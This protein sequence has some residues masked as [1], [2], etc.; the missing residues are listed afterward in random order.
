MLKITNKSLIMHNYFEV[1]QKAWG[2]FWMKFA[3]LSPAGRLATWIATWFSPPY[4]A[5]KYLARYNSQGFIS[6]SSAIY[7]DSIKFGNNVFI[8]DRVT[9]YQNGGGSVSLGD[10]VHLHQDSCVETGE[11]GALSIGN[12]T[13]IQSRCQFSAY[14][15]P[16]TIGNNVQIAPSCSFYSYDHATNLGQNI[17]DLPLSSKGGIVIDDDVWVGCGVIVLDG[18]HLGKGCV[19]GAGSVVTSDIPENAIAVGAPAKVRKMRTP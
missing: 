19:I 13:H 12:N 18:V 10:Q 11:G 9:V 3:G 8:G 14:K 4:K 15:S 1:P 2:V 7:H 6:P 16:I 17:I 5:R